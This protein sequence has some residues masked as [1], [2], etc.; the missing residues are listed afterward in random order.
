VLYAKPVD[1]CIA[2]VDVNNFY[3][4]CERVFLPSLKNHAIAVLSNNDGC[5][6]SRSAEAKS[7]GV[8]MGE[9]YHLMKPD[10]LKKVKFFSSNYELYGDLSRRFF[11][12]LK[13]LAPNV[14]QY[15]IDEVFLDY[16]L[17]FKDDLIELGHKIKD[18]VYQWTKLPVCVGFGHTKTLAKLANKYAKKVNK[19]NGVCNLINHAKLD[20]I[21]ELTPIED[22]W[23]IGYSHA[24]NLK[25]ESISNALAFRNAK[26]SWVK[27]KFTITG[28]NIQFELK[29]IPSIELEEIQPP[30][31]N[32]VMTRSFGRRI[33]TLEDMRQ[34][35]ATYSAI[36]CDKLR[37]EK[38]FT[39][40]IGI[41]LRA[42]RTIHQN[43]LSLYEY[44]RLGRSTNS[45]IL[46]TQTVLRLLELKFVDGY[47]Y[48]KAGVILANLRT[49]KHLEQSL[50]YE[51]SEEDVI[52][53]TYFSIRDRH[54][55]KKLRLAAT[56]PKSPKW[57]MRSD[58]LSPRYTTRAEDI[59]VIQLK[60][61]TK[62]NT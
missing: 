61:L 4:S 25:K 19:L 40:L 55:K 45:V 14:E 62:L 16:G 42:E 57:K 27:K 33:T 59:R 53:D 37:K 5:V 56:G 26:E 22:I 36:A 49:E 47:E 28:L 17:H 34:A 41:Y 31:K 21:L 48:K 51:N 10:I 58:L 20:T 2:L 13:T 7:L 15:S 30:K 50:F 32:I 43:K 35:I 8:Q 9:P 24:R 6:I 54:G 18:M 44:A 23:G 1:S 11:E 12:T 38:E 3:A 29:G 60:N 39:S 46:I 52:L